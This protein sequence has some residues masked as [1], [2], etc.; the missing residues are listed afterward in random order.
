[1]KNTCIDP[2][3]A[4]ISNGQSGIF[5]SSCSYL[6]SIRIQF[7]GNCSLANILVFIEAIR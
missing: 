2:V 3:N 4:D 7:Y 1:M 5:L 6:E